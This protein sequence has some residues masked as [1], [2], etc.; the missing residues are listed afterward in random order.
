MKKYFLFPIFFLLALIILA[1]IWPVEV[2]AESNVSFVKDKTN[3][4]IGIL[5]LPIITDEDGLFISL[6][7]LSRKFAWKINEDNSNY[8]VQ[9]NDKKIDLQ[10][11]IDTDITCQ[12]IIFLDNELAVCAE[13]AAN[14][15]KHLENDEYQ[16]VI[17]FST[18]EIYYKQNQVID[19]NLHLLNISSS[20]QEINFNT[21]QNYELILTGPAATWN[22][23]AERPYRQVIRSIE[24][25]S[26]EHKSWQGKFSAENLTP[27]SYVLKGSLSS[28]PAITFNSQE[29][30]IISN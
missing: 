24:I 20:T 29:I 21:G 28:Q 9:Q 30:E 12:E 13:L 17:W 22:I 3:D 27:G 18:T 26:H 6:Q 16:F 5:H 10:E 14:L 19:Y 7:E 8:I 23:T 4:N 15:I 25:A 2:Q 11:K 1:G